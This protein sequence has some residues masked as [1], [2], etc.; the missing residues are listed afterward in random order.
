MQKLLHNIEFGKHPCSKNIRIYT[1]SDETN[2]I[3]SDPSYRM[4]V[5]QFAE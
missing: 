3:Y 4:I 1:Y 5:A 2:T